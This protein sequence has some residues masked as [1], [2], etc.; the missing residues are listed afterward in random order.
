MRIRRY[1]EKFLDALVEGTGY[2]V[3]AGVIIILLAM[4]LV[5]TLSNVHIERET[6]ESFAIITASLGFI[7]LLAKMT[8]Q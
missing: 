3:G 5:N 4:I 6:A 1:L 2:M 7:L 8:N